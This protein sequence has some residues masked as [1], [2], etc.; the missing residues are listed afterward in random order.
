MTSSSAIE[1]KLKREIAAR[2]AA[3]SLLEAKSLELFNANQQLEVA[4]KQVEQRSEASFKRLE[5]QQHI[6]RILIHF[7][8]TFLRSNLDDVLLSDLIKQLS[9]A[10]EGICY[11]I[12]LTDDLTPT[13]TNNR[14]K[15]SI[16][17]DEDSDIPMLKASIPIQVEQKNVGKLEVRLVGEDF[18]LAFIES[19][20][21]L[22]CE[23]LSSSITRQLI[24]LRLVK[25]KE[26]AEASERSTR[27]F[28][29][30]INHELR[31]PLNGLLGSVEL[32]ADTDLKGAQQELHTNLSQSGQLLRSI[33]NDLL[34]FSKIDAGMLELID[35]TF[36]WTNLQSTL[37]S[38]FE[39]KAAEKQI[40]F[41]VC[42]E[43]FE[44]KRLKGDLE[45]LTQ[46]FV[47]L[48]G[49]A[50]KFTDEG[51]VKVTVSLKDKGFDFSVVDTGI[52][53]SRSAQKKLFQPFTQADRSSSRNY[54]G[55][56]LGLAICKRLVELMGG[57]ISLKSEVGEGTTFFGFLPV[58][59]EEVDEKERVQQ[60]LDIIAQDF[61]AL[62]VL[63]VDDI[64]MNQ[65]VITKMLSKVGI[66]PDLAVN[67]LEA[68]EHAT[69]QQYDIIFMDCRMPVMDGFEATK[70]LRDAS[71][72][73]PIVA[74]TAGTTREE[75]QTCYDVG[76]DDILS[77][78]YTAKDLTLTLSKWGPSS[79]LDAL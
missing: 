48:I 30:M 68:V 74:L 20:M 18:D 3:E 39:H 28:L 8:R 26:R 12:E 10:A 35:S 2:K 27:E 15:S 77:K 51:S 59:I 16:Q 78:P 37:C 46:I 54:E 63:V 73:K 6:E 52:G 43:G 34:D 62:K 56:G 29:A 11:H 49:N 60:N 31:T 55:T 17:N 69:N 13:L 23:L 7:G 32:L 21:S 22:V 24:N 67:G 19:Q 44:N 5:F 79:G 1:R 72:A 33:I 66:T 42:S 58:G 25:S 38:I 75:R 47:N 36:K 41:T 76:M 53:I 65:V 71:Y 45:R 4:L 40:G 64:K 57:S 70:R 9:E 61:S 50:I 14:F